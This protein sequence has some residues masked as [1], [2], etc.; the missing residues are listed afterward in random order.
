MPRPHPYELIADE[1]KT[2]LSAS[3]GVTLGY[4]PGPGLRHANFWNRIGSLYSCYRPAVALLSVF[5]AE[6]PHTPLALSTLSTN[7]H[8]NH[9]QARYRALLPD[10]RSVDIHE[11]RYGTKTGLV[12]RLRFEW[13][14][15]QRPVSSVG[16]RLDSPGF[17]GAGQ[18]PRPTGRGAQS[19][20][21]KSAQGA[22]RTLSAPTQDTGHSPALQLI[23]CF[24][25]QVQQSPFFDYM[26]RSTAEE[27]AQGRP[28][29]FD[30][31]LV[32]CSIEPGLG[33]VTLRQPH[34]H[35]GLLK[36][37]DDG[38][39]KMIAAVNSIQRVWLSQPLTAGGFCQSESELHTLWHDHGAESS[40]RLRLGQVGG[41][42]SAGQSPVSS[43][44]RS[45]TATAPVG[46]G[47]DPPAR[48]R[49][50]QS[51]PGSSANNAGRTPSAPAQDTGQSPALHPEP[52]NYSHRA[53][54]YY[55][56]T[57]LTLE[58]GES[59]DLV[60]Q[61][62]FHTD[63]PGDDLR[64]AKRLEWEAKHARPY[65]LTS[66]AVDRELAR[67]EQGWRRYLD[68][69]VPQ[70]ECS[71]KPLERYWYYVWY[72]LR[73][74]RTAPG[75]HITA[76][77][78]APSKYMYWGPWIWDAYF[79]VLGERWLKDPSIAKD[80][81]R[82]VL[83]MQFPNGF[84]PVCS[85]S[86]YRMCFHEDVPGYRSPTGG[87]YASYVPPKLRGYKEDAH[88]FE[89]SFS[90]MDHVGKFRLSMSH[91]EK[92]QTPLITS[93][94]ECLMEVWND[95]L[96]GS[97][98]LQECYQYLKRFDDWLWLRRTDEQGRF[99]LWH[100][101]ESGW[102]DATRHYPVPHLPFDVQTH[103]A[104]HRYSLWLVRH[105][106]SREAVD[107]KTEGVLDSRLDRSRRALES[108]WNSAN[109][110]YH[111]LNMPAPSEATWSSGGERKQI[112]AAGFYALL[113]GSKQECVQRCV[114]ALHDPLMFGRP[115]PIPTLAACDQDYKPHGWG[116]NGPV[117]LQVNYFAMAGLFEN[118]EGSAAHLLWRKTR[119]LILRDDVP[120]SFE[121]YDPEL[122]TGM[123]CPDYSWQAMI[124]NLIIEYLAG[125]G[126]AWIRPALPPDMSYLKI[127]NLPG[128]V[129]AMSIQRDGP[130]ISIRIESEPGQLFIDNGADERGNLAVDFDLL[131]T[132]RGARLN[133]E[134]LV[135]TQ[136]DQW[137]ASDQFKTTVWEFELKCQ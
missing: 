29:G 10:G 79:H 30:E 69:E 87:G 39:G 132:I 70:L 11:D 75:A 106:V 137:E 58:A 113:M 72:V 115:Y 94:V 96:F 109:R 77:F 1:R 27:L 48:G 88:P 56:S 128:P 7:W 55:M 92:T 45:A 74:N 2:T 14:A 12:C 49:G 53:P 123:G 32:Q 124:L 93:A 26:R 20:P 84:I 104:W 131:G 8:P 116:W 114:E 118:G 24:H 31:P 67:E 57:R 33:L 37:A 35:D 13:S 81:I 50:A 76:P 61:T 28:P 111:D 108:Y 98:F 6:D 3:G 15:G 17:A 85:G 130:S 101:D 86:Q 100:G 134:D 68:S 105:S 21:G 59:K 60:I 25:G 36:P 62:D 54:L 110:W 129:S 16:A 46:A 97:E 102:D 42:W 107:E 4:G 90:Y 133:G 122:G 51:A 52:L 9:C 103:C 112:S 78:T 71:D 65:R 117:W 99:I 125:L 83:Q 64:D 66:K 82:A 41:R 44:S 34:P 119:D 89:A 23:L 80:S 120:S 127:N 121:L 40:L 73:A 63:D 19:A 18:S 38:S 91:N 135:R 22:G 95:E 5:C 43:S 126:F 47:P 136:Q